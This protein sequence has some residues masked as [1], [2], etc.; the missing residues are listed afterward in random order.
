MDPYK[1]QD[2]KGLQVDFRMD[3]MVA[4]FFIIKDSANHSALSEELGHIGLAII[5]AVPVEDIAFFIDIFL[6]ILLLIEVGIAV[7]A[8][9][10]SQLCLGSTLNPGLLSKINQKEKKGSGLVDPYKRQD[11]KGL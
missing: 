2:L 3:S 8:A 9:A 6:Q 5:I 10:H 11:L 1:R 7:V 4:V